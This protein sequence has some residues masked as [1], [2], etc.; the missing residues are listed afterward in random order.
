MPIQKTVNHFAMPVDE[1]ETLDRRSQVAFSRMILLL[2]AGL[3]Y[4]QSEIYSALK[5]DLEFRKW[6]GRSGYPKLNMVD[7]SCTGLQVI[8]HNLWRN[9]Y[10]RKFATGIF[11]MSGRPTGVA[12]EI[13][14]E[15]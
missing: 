2:E 13:R 12:W 1:Q 11:A 4:T 5:K 7:R 8:L 14:R 3:L 15:E 6:L 10:I 9:G